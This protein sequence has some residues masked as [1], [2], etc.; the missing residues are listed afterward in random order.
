MHT[1]DILLVGEDPTVYCGGTAKD[2]KEAEIKKLES[3]CKEF[4]LRN[5]VIT[6]ILNLRDQWMLFDIC[7]FLSGGPL[8]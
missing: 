8:N 1:L 6:Q 5:T 2:Q 4:T 3:K 7:G